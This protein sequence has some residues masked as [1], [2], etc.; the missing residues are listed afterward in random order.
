MSWQATAWAKKVQ[1]GIKGYGAKLVLLILAD[2]AHPETGEAWPSQEM[3][4]R[5]AEMPLRTVQWSLKCLA[6]RKLITVLRKGNQYQ[7]TI[8]KLHVAGAPTHELA[9]TALA[10]EPARS[11]AA[12]IA[13]TRVNPQGTTSEPA[14]PVGSSSQ[15][16]PSPPTTTPTPEWMMILY[17]IM[18]PDARKDRLLMDWVRPHAPAAVR[19]AAY[20]LVDKWHDVKKTPE[21]KNGYQ[22]VRSTFRNWVKV[23]EKSAKEGTAARKGGDR[24]AE[25]TGSAE[26]I[27]A[28]KARYQRRTGKRP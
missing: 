15:E 23:A 3:I 7:A 19:D 12:K 6:D 26:S 10:G 2:Y 8:Y 18:E 27:K 21:R 28:A 22:D 1:T 9:T 25:P 17:D 11:G 16:E 13:G 4:S 20:D 24:R 5:D 14:I